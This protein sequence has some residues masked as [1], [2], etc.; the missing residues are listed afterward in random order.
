MI[1]L[2]IGLLGVEWSYFVL[3]MVYWYLWLPFNK[4][5]SEVLAISPE[6][7]K[8]YEIGLDGQLLQKKFK[9]FFPDLGSTGQMQPD[10]AIFCVPKPF[11][12]HKFQISQF[13]VILT[14]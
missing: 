14:S 4:A 8:W 3:I 5:K 1:L 7:S 13:W 2:D 12:V 10:L 6:I 11:L 9:F